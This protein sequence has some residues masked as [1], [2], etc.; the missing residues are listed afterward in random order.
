MDR[1]IL[2]ANL[3]LLISAAVWGFGFIAQQYGAEAMP[4]LSYNTCRFALGAL[5]LVPLVLWMNRSPVHAQDAAK[6]RRTSIFGG[7]LTGCVL[8]AAA[9]LQQS[10]LSGTTA[11]KAAFLTGLYLIIVPIY[12]LALRQRIPKVTWLAGALF[13]AGLYLLSVQEDFSISQSD[14]VVLMGAFFWALQIMMLD[15]FLKRADALEL[16][17]WQFT[18]CALCSAV[19]GLLREPGGFVEVGSVLIPILYGGFCSVGLAYTLQCVAQK[20]ALPSHAALIMS[21]EALFA[22]LGGALFLG[23]NL[24]ARG[25]GGC[26][27]MFCAMLLSQWESFAGAG[28]RAPAGD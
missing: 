8:F 3:L 16:S 19:G 6:G 24:G 27:L 17:L 14:L 20:D 1:K 10:G 2:Q 18:G 22:A 5:S 13:L 25:Y 26:A 11:G 4:P 28:V 12:G 7:L 21:T 15:H 23:E 9:W